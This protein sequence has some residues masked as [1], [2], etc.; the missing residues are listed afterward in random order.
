[1]EMKK[2]LITMFISIAAILLMDK[3]LPYKDDN[4]NKLTLKR[5]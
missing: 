1:M 3:V 2:I 4:G 5:F